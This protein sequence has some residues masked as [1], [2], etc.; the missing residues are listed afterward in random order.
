MKHYLGSLATTLLLF[1]TAP[2]SDAAI[3]QHIP[4]PD[5]TGGMLMP[6]VSLDFTTRTIDIVLEDQG[7]LDTA[8]MYPLQ[9]FI[10][11]GSTPFANDTFDPSYGTPGPGFR[12]WYPLLDPT[13]G[14]LPFSTQF[15][16]MLHHTDITQIEPGRALYI[17]ALS[18]SEG[19]SGYDVGY[20]EDVWDM[21]GNPLPGNPDAEMWT[22]QFN[23]D[24]S[25]TRGAQIPAPYPALPNTV[26]WGD[27][28][29]ISMWHPVFIAQGPGLYSA[30]FE[31]YLGDSLGTPIADWESSTIELHWQSVGVA[32][33]P[34]PSSVT[35]ILSAGALLGLGGYRRWRTS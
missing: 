10:V 12:G 32:A 13:A 28:G 24:G 11:N 8:P 1:A 27:S 34:E 6:Y 29:G 26:Y 14:H 7:G 25:K 22:L 5:A 20:W 19:L 35:M 15:G 18:I 17:R 16:F 21:E 30:T 33:I 3:L 31:V 9:E 23:A 4:G 2:G